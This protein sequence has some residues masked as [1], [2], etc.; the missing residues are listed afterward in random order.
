[1]RDSTG[2]GPF[3]DRVDQVKPALRLAGA[4]GE[5]V[6]P[7]QPVPAETLVLQGPRSTYITRIWE[8]REDAAVHCKLCPAGACRISPMGNCMVRVKGFVPTVLAPLWP[9]STPGFG[10]TAPGVAGLGRA[11]AGG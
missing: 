3:G 2:V 9:K 4:D 10:V 8:D 5:D 6:P 1:M 7:G 11:G